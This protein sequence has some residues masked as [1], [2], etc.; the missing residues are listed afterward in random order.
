MTDTAT[1]KEGTASDFTYGKDQ[2]GNLL[3]DGVVVERNPFA[4]AYEVPEDAEEPAGGPNSA[5]EG[6]E[7]EAEPEEEPAKPVEEPTPEPPAEPEKYKFSLKVHGEQIEQELTREQLIAKL[8][9]SEDYTKKTQALAEERKRIEPYLPII[10]KPE[11]KEWLDTQV[12][13][14]A[15]E[16][17]AQPPPPAPE[18]VM[19]YRLRAQDPEFQDIKDAMVEW[20][21]TLPQHEAGF[22]DNNHRV[23]NVTY[24]RFKAARGTKAQPVPTPAPATKADPE[25][26]KKSIAAKEVAK[27]SARVESPGGQAPDVDPSREWK[28]TDRELQRAVRDGEKFVFYKGKRLDADVAW[29]LHRSTQ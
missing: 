24:D 2:Q 16:A 4:D 8:Q 10:D 25:V 12:Q 19:G 1:P 9:L 18:D 7:P 17:P 15:I 22:I 11:F 20:A 26:I 28:R 27:A 14:G 6:E 3:L 13:I 21:A 5:V 29:V 23:F